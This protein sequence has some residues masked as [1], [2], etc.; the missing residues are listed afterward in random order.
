MNIFK[1]VIA[2]IVVAGIAFPQGI[3]FAEDKSSQISLPLGDLQSI[4]VKNLTRVSV[5]DPLIADIAD[6]TSDKLLVVAKKVGQT[7]IFLWDEQGKHNISVRVTGQD[8]NMLRNRFAHLLKEA[9]LTGID[10]E[11]N[12]AEGKVVVSGVLN[13]D[14]RARFEKIMVPYFDQII[15]LVKEEE[16]EEL[17]QID[18]QITELSTTLDKALGFDWSAGSA[19]SPLAL[20]YDE[21][22][23]SLNGAKDWLKFGD[24]NRTTAIIST[25]NLFISQG[26]AR[27]LSRPRILVSSGKEASMNVGGEVP[28]S[29]VTNSSAAGGTQTQSVTFKQYGVT[30]AVTP[31][32]RDGKIDVTMN[33]QVTDID[34]SFPIRATTTSDIAY[35]TRTAQSQMTLNDRQTV[36]FAGLIRYTESETQKRVPFLSKVP[37]VGLL[38]RNTSKPSP[39]QGRELVITMTPSIMRKKEIAKDQMK[40]PTKAHKDFEREVEIVRG[41]ERESFDGDDIETPAAGSSSVPVTAAASTSTGSASSKGNGT[42]PL[43]SSSITPGASATETAASSQPVKVGASVSPYVRAVQMKISQAINYPKAALHNNWEGTVKLRLRILKDGSLANAE[44]ANTSGHEIFDQDA[45]QTAKRIAPYDAF[46]T[47]MNDPDITI[48][49][50][51]VYSRVTAAQ[52]DT[53][54]VVAAY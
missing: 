10:L 5:T 30:V 22:L 31:V 34:G 9:K 24:F 38:F 13:K 54:A 35:K 17:I 6:A 44:V 40:L 51:I 14:Q 16:N 39:D 26:K 1:R 48:S 33:L 18:M 47:G 37:V 53:Q 49:L 32:I 21:T 42:V 46:M 52:P 19:G 25:L 3:S 29:T 27:E 41:Y 15:N 2:A 11:A 43:S 45:L 36:V 12:D 8:L 23:P 7:M 28:V 50:P 20:Q 4:D